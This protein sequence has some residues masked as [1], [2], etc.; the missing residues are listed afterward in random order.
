MDNKGQE[1]KV[2][3][4]IMEDIELKINNKYEVNGEFFDTVEE[5]EEELDKIKK[6]LASNGYKVLFYDRLGFGIEKTAR[7]F[8]IKLSDL[9]LSK[10]TEITTE[11]I[12]NSYLHFHYGSA[13]GIDKVNNTIIKKYELVETTKREIKERLEK[14][15]TRVKIIT[16]EDVG[17]IMEEL[18][19]RRS[20]K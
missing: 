3:S 14:D 16:K 12:L 17:E 15:S 11:D 19:K 6:V 2:I 5:A 7:Y 13:L 4:Q 20:I 9:S 8:I 1:S 18:G 10:I